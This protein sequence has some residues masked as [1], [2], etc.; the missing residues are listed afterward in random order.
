[1]SRLWGNHHTAQRGRAWARSRW[2]IGTAAAARNW[3][4]GPMAGR[5][6]RPAMARPGRAV[7]FRA[8]AAAAASALLATI[9]ALAGPSP[10]RAAS[11]AAALNG[12][13]TT[14]NN[15]PGDQTDPH[16]SG[17]WVSYTDNSTGNYQVH[18][19]DLATGQDAT[20]PSNGGQDLLSGISGSTVVYMHS[21]ADGQNIYTYDT[22]GGS[23]PAELD[24]TPG[25]IRESPAIGGRTV[26]WVDYTADPAHPQIMAENLDT[27]QATNLTNDT[28]M[29]NLEPSVSPDGSVVT[30][31][32]CAGSFSSCN[33]W[34]AVHGSGGWTVHQLTSDSAS[35]LPHS[36]GQIVVYDSTRN[37]EE[38]IYWQPVGGGPEQKITFAGPDR[39]PHIS[40]N[41][42]VFD[43][44]DTTAST[45]NWDVYAYSLATQRL[46]RITNDLNNETLSDVSVTPGG[47]AHVVWNTLESDYNAYAF[48]FPAPTAQDPTTTSLDCAPGTIVVGG[49]T[50]C[51]ATVTGTATTGPTDPGGTVTFSSDT[52]GGVFSPASCDLNSGWAVGQASCWVT[53]TPGQVGSGTQMITA[54]YGG[55]TGHAA[56]IGTATVTVT[57]AFSGFLAPVNGP[58]TVNTGKAGKT[59]PVKWQ[60]QDAGGTYI[61]SLS[62]I[63]SI[64]Y[65]PTA[66]GSFSSDPTDALETSTTGATSLR[67]DA[68][69]NQYIYNWATPGAGCYTLFL[70][71]DSGQVLPAY[72][73]LS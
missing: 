50:T 3:R 21:T 24:P 6:R 51:T 68:T 7:T 23:P 54:S 58:P 38:D 67:Y 8:L 52:S 34:D 32:K 53:Y 49:Q 5:L 57:Y 70:T 40:G 61:S 36:N 42:I 41:L 28:T 56:S 43:H 30:W 16:V 59:Y 18:Y 37:G 73:H 26:A 60:L 46:Y 33:A 9:F 64:T 4:T 11:T 47:Q 66:C 12:Y 27:G 15:G 13:L 25:S 31:A 63:T 29:Q 71:L 44:F 39:N 65:K 35:E 20:I 62:A 14:V 1:M 17:D 22:G 10:A 72:F 19:E 55:D 69:A 45:P 2:H 48:T